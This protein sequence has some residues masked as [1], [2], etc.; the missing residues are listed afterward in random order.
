MATRD[1]AGKQVGSELDPVE[2]EPERAGE[3]ACG[4][5]LPRA[6]NVLDEHVAL[7][8]HPC[9]DRRQKVTFGNHRVVDDIENGIDRFRGVVRLH[10]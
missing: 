6:R 9:Q 2:R 1:V 3:T 7:R 10:R 8:E 5:R 4:Q